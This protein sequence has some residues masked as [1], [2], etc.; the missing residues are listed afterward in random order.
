MTGSNGEDVSVPIIWAYN[1]HFEAY[2]SG[3]QGEVRLSSPSESGKHQHPGATAHWH[4]F[5]RSDSA[6]P[7]PDSS[8]PVVQWFSEVRIAS[9]C[10]KL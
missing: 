2:L 10:F 7:R 5:R 3:A 4:G 8:I 1:H 6:D 9:F